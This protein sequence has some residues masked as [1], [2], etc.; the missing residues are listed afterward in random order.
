MLSESP[1]P[2]RS[3]DPL[4]DFPF[5][6]WQIL[7][8]AAEF[9]GG[10]E[11]GADTYEGRRLASC[12]PAHRAW[13]REAAATYAVAHENE[14]RRRDPTT[15]PRTVPV[16]SRW[17]AFNGGD[18]PD[19]RGVD[20]YELTAWGR[21]YASVDG[22]VRELWIPSL[23]TAKSFRP[24]PE[25]AAAAGIL[26]MGHP[27]DTEYYRARWKPHRPVPGPP[28]RVR[29]LDVG[30]SDGSVRLLRDEATGVT[31]DWSADEA[32]RLF[33]AQV[34]PRIAEVLDGRGRRPNQDCAKCKLLNSCPTLRRVPGLLGVGPPARK[35]RTV[36]VS[37]LR[38]HRDCPARYY[39]TRVLKLRS[40]ARES[41]AIRRG[42]AVDAWLNERHADPA[43]VPCRR[44]PL[45]ISLPGLDEHELDT[46]R[47]MIRQHRRHC[48]FDRIGMS[49]RCVPQKRVA[50]YDT[51][52]DVVVV[53]DCDLLH[54]ERGGVV[55]R[56]TKTS[57]RRYRGRLTE[58]ERY[59]QLALGVLLMESG[60]LGGDL[61]RSRIE[62]EVL[63]PDGASEEELSPADPG[64]VAAARAVL[65]SYTEAWAADTVYAEA[66][67][68]GLDCR[69]C[70][71]VRW[72]ATGR[73]RTE[74][75]ADE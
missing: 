55:L 65:Q 56:E 31:A 5:L 15:C 10:V 16:A 26:A 22:T 12:L 59:P 39:L 58:L 20:Q 51:Q 42:R 52:A 68:P 38:A 4:P 48:P 71:A 36:S 75:G 30:L 74:G 40:G 70:E 50:V 9:R 11:P 47:E 25:L 8:D 44:V 57:A 17:I 24:L 18:G 14:Q 13:A 46:A 43:R 1:Q 7:V 60:A 6:P 21:Q 41:L 45:P 63:R 69:D 19:A 67:R 72:C 35:R 61:R 27:A 28:S 33:G 23:G 54:T 32:R 53:A 2:P 62:L 34:G 73:A 49:E 29:V 37:D 3:A 66:P 64:H